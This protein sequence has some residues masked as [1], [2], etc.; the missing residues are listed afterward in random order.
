MTQVFNARDVVRMK[1]QI[2][3]HNAVKFLHKQAL[4]LT[5]TSISRWQAQAC[6][7]VLQR[8]HYERLDMCLANGMQVILIHYNLKFDFWP[9]LAHCATG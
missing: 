6:L 5:A 3:P 8:A 2:T 4:D 7:N 1:A 9:G